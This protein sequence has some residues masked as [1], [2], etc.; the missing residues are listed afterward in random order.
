MKSTLRTVAIAAGMTVAGAIVACS[1]AAVATPPASAPSAVVTTPPTSA[2]TAAASPSASG[3]ASPQAAHLTVA[4]SEVSGSPLGLTVKLPPDWQPFDNGADI[5]TSGPPAGMAFVVSVVDDT[6]ADPC[7]HLQ[8]DPKVGPTVADLA[9][10]LTA[11]PHT[12]A[13]AP[14]QT[15]IAGHQATY[16]EIAI[17]ASLPCA[18]SEFYLWQDS[19]HAYWWVQGLN[20]TARVWILEVAGRRV[21]FLTHAYPGSGGDAKARF[22][23]IL[24]S[25]VFDSAATSNSASPA[26]S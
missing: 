14:V 23:A 6:F 13:T 15:T 21:A 11:I 2:P 16:V 25:V 7:A 5:G 4:G 24:D 17:P 1:P 22:Q 8:R 26:A 20:E 12:T 3:S 18:P 19:P 10:A 9:K